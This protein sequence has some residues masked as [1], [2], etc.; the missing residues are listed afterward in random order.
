[1]LFFVET[2]VKLQPFIR[3]MCEKLTA[4]ERPDPIMSPHEPLV[5]LPPSAKV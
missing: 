5:F 4:G 3:Q 2:N 1:M